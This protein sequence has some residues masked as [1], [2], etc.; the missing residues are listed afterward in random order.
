MFQKVFQNIHTPRI[1]SSAIFYNFPS[2]KWSSERSFG[3]F[4]S[5]QNNHG[6]FSYVQ[7]ILRKSRPSYSLSCR[8][9]SSYGTRKQTGETQA[10]QSG[11]T[12]P[13]SWSSWLMS[14]Q[15]HSQL[16]VQIHGDWGR[17]LK[18]ERE[19]IFKKVKNYPRNYKPISLTSTVVQV[20][21]QIILKAITKHIKDKKVIWNSQHEF[22]KTK[23]CLIALYDEVLS[24][25]MSREQ[26][27]VFTTFFWKLSK[28]IHSHMWQISGHQSGLDTGRNNGLKWL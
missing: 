14:S 6:L 17:L 25:W 21:E 15:G 9:G 18:T 23:P 12:A 4:W 28:T 10:H 1:D 16:C 11:Q 3:Y 5:I 8:T 7:T 19:Q 26:S 20:M 13:T 27:L 22:M 24:L 2:T